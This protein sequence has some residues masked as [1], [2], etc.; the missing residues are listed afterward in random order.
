LQAMFGTV[1]TA[2]VGSIV[3]T[4]TSPAGKTFYAVV[5]AN[6]TIVTTDM[7]PS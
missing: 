7:A 1:S 2:S 5:G 4:S 3:A 6:G